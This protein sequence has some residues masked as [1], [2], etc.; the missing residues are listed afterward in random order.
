MEIKTFN[1][2]E[3]LSPKYFLEQIKPYLKFLL[4]YDQD[5]LWEMD[6]Q[7][8]PKRLQKLRRNYR[9]FAEK[10]LKPYALEIDVNKN[11][12]LLE[13]VKI[14]AAK[15]GYFSDLLPSPIGSVDWLTYRYPFHWI[16]AIKYEELCAACGGL[17][18]LIGAHSLGVAPI[19]VSGDLNIIFNHLYPILKKNKK[20]IPTLM[21]FAI[22]EPS[23]GSDVEDTE[24]GARYKPLTTAKRVSGGWLLNGRKVF[25]SDG[26]IAHAVTVFAAIEN[27]GLD[28]WTCF[29][30]YDGTPG[31]SRGRNELKMGQ[32]ASSATELIF[33]DCFVP[34]SQVVGGLE[35]GWMLNR[36]T[37]NYS[38]IP[39]GSIA[40][41]IAR[42][43][44]EHAIDFAKNHTFAGKKL[45]EYQE[46]Q[47]QIADMLILT[48]ASRMMIWQYAK[49][50]Q[51][52]Q[53]WSS[54]IKVFCSDTAMKVCEIAMD[55]LSNHSIY[56]KNYV[57]KHFRDARLTQIYE[58][59][60]QINRLAII[61]D[62]IDEL[63]N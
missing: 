63:F 8:L 18:L 52:H 40:L 19:I 14:E 60:N 25:I 10:H 58:G 26:D 24:G 46:I 4:K 32:R 28:S 29:L 20:G 37:L 17:G 53:S 16:A 38:R 45:I 43:A 5:K 34:D 56:H 2:E 44:M 54:M 57:E 23:G 12:E 15:A 31:F 50:W 62:Q 35:K 27:K 47:M 21:A 9:A 13:K 33:E 7:L 55:I 49:T 59:T 48:S 22:T 30:V 61:E 6:T 51:A 11:K 1:L 36:L 41:G 3:K 39:V 42:G